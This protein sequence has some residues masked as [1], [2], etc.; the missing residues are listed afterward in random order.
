MILHINEYLH[1][2]SQVAHYL[3]LG[4][5]LS[6]ARSSVQVS[7]LRLNEGS[8]KTAMVWTMGFVKQEGNQKLLQLIHGSIQY[9]F[10]KYYCYTRLWE[11]KIK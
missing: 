5:S 3:M 10:A 9:S 8:N 11:L 4:R 7:V 1:C 2:D 6:H